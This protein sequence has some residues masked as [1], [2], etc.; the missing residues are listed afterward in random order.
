MTNELNTIN[1]DSEEQPVRER[2]RTSVHPS[3]RSK[4][5]IRAWVRGDLISLENRDDGWEY[6]WCDKNN[7]VKM[8]QREAQGF[9]R[10][11]STSG[12]KAKNAG[13]ADIRHSGPSTAGLVEMGDLVLMALDKDLAN[14]RRAAVDEL[15]KDA[16]QGM[17]DDLDANM[18]RI[19]AP[20]TGKIEIDL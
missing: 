3:K 1:K 12:L 14:E 13:S 6:R 7:A 11:T 15:N 2:K 5:N 18:N 4:K 17:T 10:V 20:R 16:M 8:A 19:G 9:V